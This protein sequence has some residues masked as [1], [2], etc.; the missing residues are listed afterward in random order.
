M[1]CILY[2]FFRAILTAYGGSQARGLIWVTAA[3]LHHSSQ[4]EARG[5]TCNLMIPSWIHFQCA[6]RGTPY[7]VLLIN[8]SSDSA[9]EGLW[10]CFYYQMFML[11]PWIKI[12]PLYLIAELV[13]EKL[14]PSLLNLSALNVNIVAKAKNNR[15]RWA[16]TVN[17]RKM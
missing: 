6:T 3:G 13:F 2:F 7:S 1:P 10:V 15:G 14:T 4:T 11:R 8:N 16:M 5:R 17:N 9:V 12:L